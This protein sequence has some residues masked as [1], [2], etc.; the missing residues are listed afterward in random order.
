MTE[1]LPVLRFDRGSLLA[2]GFA[3]GG[4]PRLP[5]LAV[6][7]A[8]VGAYRALGL[9][10]RALVRHLVHGG[11]AFRDAARAFGEVQ[12]GRAPAM[13]YPHQRAALTAWSRG[14]RGMVELPTGAGKTHVALLALAQ[15][16]RDALVLV[17]TLEL[18]TQWCGVIERELGLVPGAIGGGSFELRPVTVCTYASA[19]RHAAAFGDR[20]GLVVFDECHH[21]GGEG[22]A[23]I[24][25]EL[26]APYRLGLSATLPAEDG[27][28]ATLERLIGPLVYAQPIAALSGRYLADYRVEVR[29]AEL[30][31]AERAAYRAD[32]ET[33]LAFARRL[34]VALTGPRGWQ[35]FVFGASR[36]AEGR[37]ALAAYYRQKQLAFSAEA[38][39]DL[40][41]EVLEHHRGE[42]VL[43]FTNDNATAFRVARRFLLPLITHQ[44]RVPERREILA[45]FRDGRWPALVTS[46]VLNEGVDVPAAAVA[47][48]LSGNAS[49]RE[50]V[51]RLG[52]ILRKAEGKEAV[53]Y[54]LLTRD[55]AEEHTSRRRRQHDAYEGA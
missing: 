25:E 39:F 27:A 44:T 33:Y 4:D 52:R 37:A 16:A 2:E 32:R 5:P 18:V 41:A 12:P 14:K 19:F 30:T 11:V 20:F 36:S 35:Q 45:R 6:W 49:V 54:E 9:H 47:V 40:C 7:D 34:G 38:K 21:L 29:Y 42:R 15:V 48:I 46:K 3:P 31:P 43:I 51:Q 22:Y 17:P 1:E 10:Y 55:T 24:G 28:R 13:P 26:I 8:R 53:L 50:H 23:G